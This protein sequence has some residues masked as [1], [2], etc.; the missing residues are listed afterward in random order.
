MMALAANKPA[1]NALS[2]ADMAEMKKR[3]RGVLFISTVCVFSAFI[4]IYSKFTLHQAWGLPLFGIAMLIGLGVQIR[5]IV[6]VVKASRAGK[7]S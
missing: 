1:P 4:G 3:Y 2:D 7:G 6:G 5:F